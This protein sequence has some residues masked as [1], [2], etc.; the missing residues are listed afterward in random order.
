MLIKTFV[1]ANWAVL[2]KGYNEW[3]HDVE[4][5]SITTHVDRDGVMQLLAVYRE[6][7]GAKQARPN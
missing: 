7:L 4:V 6:N 1:A 5:L 3:S 2:E